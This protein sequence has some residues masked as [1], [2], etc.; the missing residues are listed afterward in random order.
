VAK[1]AD[2]RDRKLV[3]SMRETA[4][5]RKRA[6]RA[7]A[8]VGLQKKVSEILGICLPDTDESL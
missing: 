3:E 1:V 8:I 5:W 4:R 7:E 2:Q 6:E